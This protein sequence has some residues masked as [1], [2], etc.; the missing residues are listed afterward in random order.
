MLVSRRFTITFALVCVAG[1]IAA[2][3]ALAGPTVTVRIEGESGT[4]LPQTVVTL[5]S[6]EPV[7]DC[8]AN[9]V[10]AAIN[11]AVNGNWDHGE[12]NGGAG[13]FTETILG[14]THDFTHNSDTWAE[15]VNGKWGGGICTDKL[16]TDGDEV[17]M[18]ADHEPEPFFSPTVWPL[19]AAGAPAAVQAGVPFAVQV[20]EIRTPAG[21]FAEAGQGTPTPVAG[22]TVGG[23]G[24]TSS[25]SDSSGTAMVTL[26][27]AGNVTLRASKPGDAPSAPFVVCVHNGNDGNCGA[28]ASAAPGSSG[29][30]GSTTTSAAAYKGPYAI[31]ATAAGVLDSHVYPLARAPRLLRG[32]AVAHTQIASVSLRLRRKL[33]GRCF[34][35]NGITERFART[36]CGGGSFFKVAS[37]PSFSYLLPGA[38]ARGRY[39]LDIEAT[40]VAGNRTSLARGSSRL[41]FY[42]R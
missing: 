13:N 16:E 3:N 1:V 26:T 8:P 34:A 30:L 14:E 19:V 15:W 28:A 22:A 5:N 17:L 20:S 7:S 27:G 35:Y 6:P 29:V 36:R 21:T 11:L 31:V 23:A 24:A 38:L 2:A 4:L 33:H 10:A 25:S 42:V 12:S 37:T 40:D 39:V 18:I 9:S 41:V 32:T